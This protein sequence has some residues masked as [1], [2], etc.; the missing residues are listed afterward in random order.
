MVGVNGMIS[1]KMVLGGV[2]FILVFFIFLFFFN[3]PQP[4]PTSLVDL[5]GEC[6]DVNRSAYGVS[7][8]VFSEL[9]SPPRCFNSVVRRF[10][11]NVFTDDS[12][13]SR[14]YFLQPEFFPNF[15]DNG[16]GFWTNPDASRYGVV[17]FGAF[18][19][20]QTISLRRGEEKVVRVFVHAG[21]GVR[22][23]QGMRI[24]SRFTNLSKGIR[25]TLDDASESGFLLGP[26]F[27]VFDASWVHPLELRLRVERDA[28]FH[29][30]SV[31]LQSA[32]PSFSDE[33]A[34]GDNYSLYFPATQ[35]VGEQ[36]VAR[37]LVKVVE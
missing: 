14:E 7:S 35:Y 4:S 37:I 10:H 34:W 15:L 18:P 21:F 3:S 5:S 1:K 24:V 32:P 29:V 9:P 33:S 8:A 36:A 28:P 22:S 11:E 26:T 25:V 13:F 17:G 31:V 16:L 27:P 23:F 12:F 6:V 20:E 19:A 30:A 2:F